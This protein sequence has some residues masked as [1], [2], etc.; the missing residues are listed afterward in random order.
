MSLKLT[1]PTA[2]HTRLS[3]FRRARLAT[4]ASCEAQKIGAEIYKEAENQEANDNNTD[5]VKVTD[6]NKGE[7][8]VVDGE[9]VDEGK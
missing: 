5:D 6:N 1:R 7:D 3:I 9:V 8:E 2:R 4:A